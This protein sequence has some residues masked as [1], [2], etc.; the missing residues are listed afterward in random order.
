MKIAIVAITRHGI[1]LAGKVIAALPGAKLFAPEKFRSEAESVSSHATCY[2][3]KTGD[4]IPELF[5]AFDGIIAIVSLG[6][7]VRL[8]APHLKSKE[9]DPAVVVL[10]E[11]GKFAIRCFP[12]ISVAPMRLPAIWRPPWAP[13]RC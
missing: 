5:A 6:A 9:T 1:V 2:T 7:V 8:I 4:Q 3:G 11:S 13:P 12:A 10:D